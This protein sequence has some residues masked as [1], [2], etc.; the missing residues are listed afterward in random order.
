MNEVAFI[1][2]IHGNREALER[3]LPL[4][5]DRTSRLVFLGDYVNRGPDSRGVLQ[6]LDELSHRPDLSVRLLRGNHDQLLLDAL[7]TRKLGTLLR[8]GGAPTITS[9]VG[10]N[11]DVDVAS[12]LI[13]SV[14]EA[15]I[16]LLRSSED[17]VV[18]EGAFAS[19]HPIGESQD[20]PDG[21]E[22]AICG[23]APQP[24]SV[25]LITQRTAL[26]DTGCGTTAD[27]RL[28]AL[29]WPSL[30]WVQDNGDT[31]GGR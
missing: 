31:S 17:S 4:V 9:Y 25:P 15:H 5:L 8:A 2:D 14:P 19:H 12:Q 3:L 10:A 18:I 20:L 6:V 21:A 7:T 13:D 1:G 29:F 28:T 30:D 22:F 23:H 11:P 24:E 26:I 27:G 16:R